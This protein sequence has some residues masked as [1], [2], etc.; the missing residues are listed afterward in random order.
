[1]YCKCWLITDKSCWQINNNFI[2]QHLIWVDQWKGSLG[3][4]SKRLLLHVYPETWNTIFVFT[5]ICI[6]VFF[7]NTPFL[8]HY[9]TFYKEMNKATNSWLCWFTGMYVVSTKSTGFNI[10]VINN[11]ATHV[12]TG[13]R[14]LLGNQDTQRVPGYIE[15][16]L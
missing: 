8:L 11:D 3:R 12:L 6:R 10:D 1:M 4:G 13:I 2:G 15:V 5:F 9:A 16:S 7:M 14:V